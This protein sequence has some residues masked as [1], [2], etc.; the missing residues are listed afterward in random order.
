MA[1][2]QAGE[3]PRKT[4]VSFEFPEYGGMSEYDFYLYGS[5]NA[6]LFLVVITLLCIYKLDYF[7]KIDTVRVEDEIARQELKYNKDLI[8]FGISSR[9][10]QAKEQAEERIDGQYNKRMKATGD[11][12]HHEMERCITELQ[13]INTDRNLINTRETT[14]TNLIQVPNHPERPLL[15]KALRRSATTTPKQ[16]PN[17]MKKPPM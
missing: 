5:I 8:R 2:Q 13:N 16:T 9:K 10:V 3:E 7:H 14:D 15:K 12:L 17:H 11:R 1:Q 6:I 4:V